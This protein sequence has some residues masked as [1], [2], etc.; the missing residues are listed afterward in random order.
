MKTQ[1]SPERPTLRQRLLAVDEHQ[2]IVFMW[3]DWEQ[4]SGATLEVFEAFKIYAGHIHSVE[5]FI[6]NDD[7]ANYPGWPIDG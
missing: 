6:K 2:G 3:L 5:A 7:P 4:Q 1:P